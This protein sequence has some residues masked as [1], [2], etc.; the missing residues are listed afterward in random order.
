MRPEPVGHSGACETEVAIRELGGNSRIPSSADASPHKWDFEFYPPIIAVQGVSGN[1]LGTG[2]LLVRK[3]P[4]P[5]FGPA[6]ILQMVLCCIISRYSLPQRAW[7]R[8]LR[9]RRG[10][11]RRQPSSA[12][13]PNPVARFCSRGLDTHPKSSGD[14]IGWAHAM[15]VLLGFLFEQFE[16]CHLDTSGSGDCCSVDW[17]AASVVL[18][19]SSRPPRLNNSFF[20][21]EI[22]FR[23]NRTRVRTGI[24]SCGKL[25]VFLA[26][27]GQAS[28]LRHRIAGSTRRIPQGL[29]NKIS[30]LN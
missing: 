29:S 25:S 15:S 22:A 8:D 24:L 16:I 9:F 14:D 5:M 28:I 30:I 1:G 10:P 6:G 7:V 23:Q 3:G 2:R 13:L 17:I 20:L 27:C 12:C 11:A 18:S 26:Y 21:S 19:T 4:G